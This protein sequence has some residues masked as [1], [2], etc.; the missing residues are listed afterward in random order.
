M[1]TMTSSK[2]CTWIQPRVVSIFSRLLEDWNPDGATLV[3]HWRGIRR[4]TRGAFALI[5][6]LDET[7]GDSKDGV[8]DNSIN[9]FG[10]LVLY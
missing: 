5:L 10:D 9:A 2:N 3:A 7:V 4:R 1:Q 8:D 6:A